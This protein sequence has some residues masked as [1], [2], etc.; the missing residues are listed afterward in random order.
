MTKIIKTY[1]YYTLDQA[2]TIINEESRQKWLR[3]QRKWMIEKK[4]RRNK[5][6]RKIIYRSVVAAGVILLGISI[7]TFNLGCFII[8]IFLLSLI[9]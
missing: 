1:D 5:L 9:V 4:K 2:R 6:I 3:R 7:I 8:G